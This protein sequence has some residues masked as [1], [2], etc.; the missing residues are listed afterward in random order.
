MTEHFDPYHRWLGIPPKHQPADHY[1]LLGLERFEDDAEVIV[2]A[3]ERQMT[4]VRRYALGPH[5][6][7]SQEILNELAAAQSCLL[8]PVQKA[9]YDE[10]LR[11]RQMAATLR[12][13]SPPPASVPAIPQ[14]VTTPPASK[15][16]KHTSNLHSPVPEM[17]PVLRDGVSSGRAPRFVSSKSVPS[18][19]SSTVRPPSL[20]DR[21]LVVWARSQTPGQLSTLRFLAVGVSLVLA[22]AGLLIALGLSSGTLTAKRNF[23]GPAHIREDARMVRT[24]EHTSSSPAP[25]DEDT[26]VYVTP[27]PKRK[28]PSLAAAPFDAAYA[29]SQQEAWS[30]YLGQ[31]VDVTNS[32]GM[33]LILIPPGEFMM[34]SS[35]QEADRV[36]NERQHPVR[37]TEP[38]YLGV[39][40]VTQGEYERVM[41]TNPSWFSRTG[42]G[43]NKVS[44]R[45][46]RS[47]PVESVS[48][49]A[50]VEFCVRL[51]RLAAEQK[52]GRVYRLPTEAEWEYACR[53]GTT[54][55]FHF[56]SQLDGREANC[57]GNYP[58]GTTVTGP[59]LMR[60]TAVGHY[61]PNGFGLYDMHGNVWEWCRDWY[62]NYATKQ[63]DD[64]T[65]PALGGYRVVRGGSW[66]V[67]AAFCRSAVRN[68]YA[69]DFLSRDLGF[70]LALRPVDR[71]GN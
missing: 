3:A 13:M 71:S 55:P 69:M 24:L 52:L 63:V 14:A 36:D 33:K 58:Y 32:I 4:H 17:A 45:D 41:G 53:A 27:P 28:P 46:T 70:R 54:T 48:W 22:L 1:R 20:L 29:R 44:G 68:G 19:Q 65:G 7:L 60:A 39:Q 42:Q 11:Q 67:Y 50:A 38:Y 6:L 61:G 12:T 56:G 9:R 15:T 25:V 51:S 34:G 40:E 23:S 16:I 8:D 43:G 30:R 26:R 49:E 64:P 10:D 18:E 35:E 21:Q 37:L 66:D 5:Q 47:F 31:P 57:N 59:F 62:G 2:D